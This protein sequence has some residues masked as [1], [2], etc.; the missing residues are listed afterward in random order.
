MLSCDTRRCGWPPPAPARRV[1]E[2][3]WLE[4]RLSVTW[5]P[6][7]PLLLLV[8]VVVVVSS[9]EVINS[10][11]YQS[12]PSFKNHPS[13][14]PCICITIPDPFQPHQSLPPWS[15]FCVAY[16][17]GSSCPSVPAW[18]WTPSGLADFGATATRGECPPL[19][20]DADCATGDGDDAGAAEDDGEGVGEVTGGC[21]RFSAEAAALT[22]AAAA[23]P[24]TTAEWE[25]SNRFEDSSFFVCSYEDRW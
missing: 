8:V 6:P 5:L 15:D 10:L 14:I 23:T 18:S 1:R 13:P 12:D 17:A 25:K 7:P 20:D 11:F 9:T 19:G 3:R 16:P 22:A 2:S 4:R 24:V 21:G